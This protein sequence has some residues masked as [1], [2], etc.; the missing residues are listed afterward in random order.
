[1]I[2]RYLFLVG[3]LYFHLYGSAQVHSMKDSSVVHPIV[4]QPRLKSFILPTA[5]I[6]LGAYSI[7]HT[8]LINRYGIMTSRDRHLPNFNVALDDWL[9]YAPIAAGYTYGA[10]KDKHRLWLYT[11]RLLLTSI[12]NSALVL[13]IKKE[14]H[15]LRPDGDGYH[16]F[17]SGHTANAFANATLFSDHFAKGKP[18]LSVLSYASASTVGVF[19]ILNNRH[20]ASDVVAGAGFGIFSAKISQLAFKER[21]R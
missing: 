12:I 7:K 10:T 5:L 6:A 16:S 9:Q 2:F 18:W 15:I 3:I 20:W 4:Y 13:T 17:P 1:M 19:R 14:S 8:T 21:K 11:K